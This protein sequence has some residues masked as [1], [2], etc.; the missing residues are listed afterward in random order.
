[1]SSI[2]CLAFNVKLDVVAAS[3]SGGNEVIVVG[4]DVCVLR[5][6]NVVAT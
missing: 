5:G 3:S 2:I 6:L 1:M 4:G